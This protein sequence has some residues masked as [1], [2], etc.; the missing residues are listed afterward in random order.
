[1]KPTKTPKRVEVESA[2]GG[3]I[4]KPIEDP[5]KGDSEDDDERDDNSDDDGNGEGDGKGD[6][7]GDDDIE[8]V[9]NE[10]DGET[11]V[12]VGRAPKKCGR[13]KK[14]GHNIVTCPGIAVNLAR[15]LVAAPLVRTMRTNVAAVCA[16]PPGKD[17]KPRAPSR[18]VRH[19]AEKKEKKAQK[20]LQRNEREKEA[21][22]KGPK[23]VGKA[24]SPRT[25]YRVDR[26]CVRTLIV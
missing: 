20:Q 5:S 21:R 22:S 18:K 19:A 1:V 17:E 24:D 16:E 8:V 4:A 9:G 13:C 2:R 12:V 11:T 7:E 15:P 25:R 14:Q 26:P 23:R 10:K 6:R 3:N